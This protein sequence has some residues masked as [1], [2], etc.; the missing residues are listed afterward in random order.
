MGTAAI[1][2]GELDWGITVCQ[3]SA[4]LALR[5]QITISSSLHMK[6]PISTC[7]AVLSSDV[8]QS[9]VHLWADSTLWAVVMVISQL[10]IFVQSLALCLLAE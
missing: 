4:V 1:S 3:H 6:R 9:S 8:M 10:F 7:I 2:T 5:F